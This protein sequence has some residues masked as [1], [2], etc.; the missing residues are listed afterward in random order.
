M[1][2]IKDLPRKTKRNKDPNGKVSNRIVTALGR[3]A[4]FEGV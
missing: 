4:T 1:E 2:E 3:E